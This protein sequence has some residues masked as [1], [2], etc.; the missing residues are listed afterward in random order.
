MLISILNTVF[1]VPYL[2]I[3]VLIAA[4]LDIAIHYTKATTRFTL[5][6]IW[7]CVMCWPAVLVLLFFAFIFGQ[8]E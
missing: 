1:S 2:V 7:G 8:K 6:E 5:L 3:G 4:L